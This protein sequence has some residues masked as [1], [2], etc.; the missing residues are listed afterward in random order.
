MEP[1]RRHYWRAASIGLLL[2]LALVSAASVS[3]Y[4]QF[5]A[6]IRYLQQ[7]LNRTAQIKYIAVLQD[8]KSQ[9]VL[10]LTFDPQDGALQIQR[11]TALREGR[12]DSMQLWALPA[13]GAAQS[14]GVLGSSASTLRL[15]VSEAL[16]SSVGRLAV[17]VENKG[18]AE[19]G[20]GPRLPY[21]LTGSLIQ[22][23]R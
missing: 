22:K 2:V 12:E 18:G 16:L 21:L 15:A 11:L 6:Q 14:L 17:S 8:E 3:M 10:L 13:N 7:Q 20:R 23:S 19:A 9:P 1:V 5:S 4:E